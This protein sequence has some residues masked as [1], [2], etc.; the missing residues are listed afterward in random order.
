MFCCLSIVLLKVHISENAANKEARLS[1]VEAELVRCRAA[2]TRFEQVFSLW[3]VFIVTFL[4][5]SFFVFMLE[6]ITRGYVFLWLTDCFKWL[7][8]KWILVMVY[9]S[10][11]W[12]VK[13][14][15]GWSVLLFSNAAKCLYIYCSYSGLDFFLFIWRRNLNVSLMVTIWYVWAG[16][17]D[18]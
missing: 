5:L 12:L 9:C 13:F 18:C 11:K 8:S 14:Q 10:G 7:I 6:E 17:G 3:L 16:E 15:L 4:W 1:E 2:C